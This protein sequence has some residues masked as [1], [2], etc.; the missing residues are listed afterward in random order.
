MPD[1]TAA[2]HYVD[3]YPWM[4]M[5]FFQENNNNPQT[6]VWW[7]EGDKRGVVYSHRDRVLDRMLTDMIEANFLLG[8]EPNKEFLLFIKHFESLRRMKVTNNKGIER[9]VWESTNNE[10]HFVFSTLYYRLAVMSSGAGVFFN[11]D[12]DKKSVINADNI[13]DV[14]VM[15]QENNE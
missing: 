6:I 8:V 14:S 13:Y 1:N 3:T 12:V 11:Q 4:K 7:G 9:Y 2:K 15:F 10:D 5:S